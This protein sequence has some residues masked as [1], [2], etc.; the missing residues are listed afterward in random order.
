M[1]EADQ[2]SV[3]RLLERRPSLLRVATDVVK[4]WRTW[5]PL[6]MAKQKRGAAE[7]EG[8]LSVRLSMEQL[9]WAARVGAAV[10]QDS[11]WAIRWAID[12]TRESG[13]VPVVQALTPDAARKAGL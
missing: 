2:A 4:R 10:K 13:L 5:Y 12:L 3:P 9:K 8:R 11:S 7:F 1:A 6:A